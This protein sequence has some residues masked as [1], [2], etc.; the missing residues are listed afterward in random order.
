MN[1]NI[2]ILPVLV[3]LLLFAPVTVNALVAT[4]DPVHPSVAWWGEFPDDAPLTMAVAAQ[5]YAD[6]FEQPTLPDGLDAV[7]AVDHA[8][9]EK[10]A[11]GRTPNAWIDWTHETYQT[12]PVATSPEPFDDP[13]AVLMAEVARIHAALDV[14]TSA[15]EQE[16]MKAQ[17]ANLHPEALQAFARLVT[18][19]ADAYVAQHAMAHEIGPRFEAVEDLP[20][21]TGLVT[22]EEREEMA[23]RGARIT[24]AL[25]A[26]RHDI[27]DVP[28]GGDSDPLFSDPEGLV[29]LGGLGDDTYTQSGTLPD[30][31]LLVE[32]AGSDRYENSAGGAD[33]LGLL[34]GKSNLLALS[35]VYDLDGDD[36]Y[37][38]DGEVYT[39]QGAGGP[40]AIGI[41]VDVQGNDRYESLMK[42]T[43]GPFITTY[44][45]GGGQG[46]G[47][48]G[49][50]LLLDG[51]GD[52]WYQFDIQSQNGRG[53]W[54][55][56]QGFGAAGGLGI[57]SDVAGTDGWVGY[58]LGGT[59]GN[60]FLGMYNQ[61]VGFWGGVGIMSDTGLGDDLYD[62]YLYSHSTDYYA[63]GFGAFG[64]VG[65]MYED[66][67]DDVYSAVE[68]AYAATINPL[69]NCAFGTAS[70]GGQGYFIDIL[71]DDSYYGD[72]ISDK[73]AFTMN[74]GFGGIIGGFGL[75]V[76]FAGA[77][78][79][80]ME[81]HGA[82]GSDVAGRGEGLLSHTEPV[83]VY[84]DAGGVDRYVGPP[85]NWVGLGDDP[86][87]A[88]WPALG[89]DVDLVV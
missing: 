37:V 75:F 84:L 13:G 47:F 36:T 2:R 80:V 62:T 11:L 4:P 3:G 6:H 66:G 40:G 25:Q 57:A 24:Q 76:D 81:A 45:D 72:T 39:V 74:E 22:P 63:Q 31:V 29:I 77:D 68:E 53:Q 85:F 59:A 23:A 34:T 54:A 7:A 56:G 65:I 19:V 42:R 17:A 51:L 67:G 1:Q 12:E 18:V 61:G 79:H 82:A 20:D 30:P 43:V 41:L 83:G 46:Y 48:G 28:L 49:Y 8:L 27:A 88:V 26:F 60:N 69:L 15:A 87:N 86:N 35:V 52:D 38:W 21:A 10:D 44:F 50:G 70:L 9:N 14:E 58:G 71:G 64:G 73:R 89:A 32:P 5:R 55:F 16:A 78:D 33:P